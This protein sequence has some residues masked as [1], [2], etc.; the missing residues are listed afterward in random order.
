MT[1]Q[2]K[3]KTLDLPLKII[4]TEEGINFFIKNQKK[5]QKFRM[6]DN[7]EAYGF[8]LSQ[9]SPQTVQQMMNI[10]YVSKIE[11]SR[12]EFLSKRQE[13]VDISKLIIFEIL[14]ERFD[15]DIFHVLMRSDMIISWNRSN[16]GHIIDQRTKINDS[17]LQDVLTNKKEQIN[18]IRMEILEPLFKQ[19]D[20]NEKLL[21]EEKNIQL[22]LSEKYL[23]RLQPLIWFILTRNQGSADYLIML[24]DMRGHLRKYLDKSK[25]AE[26]TSLMVLELLSQAE[27]T[28][29]L[30]YAGK[31]YKRQINSESLLF[32]QT[33]R[34]KMLRELERN[35]EKL[36]LS[37]RITSRA[38]GQQQLEITIFNKESEYNAMREKINSR[39]TLEIKEK[40]LQEFY[41]DSSEVQ[42]NTDLGMY[43]LSYLSDAC[44]HENVKFESNVHQIISS[45]LTVINLKLIF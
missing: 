27:N 14:Y 5:L 40:S 15:Y 26:Y 34:E 21:P 38:D 12:T 44:R 36:Y 32:D 22:L 28:N 16:P 37:W 45:D 33:L 41:S 43:Y 6:A 25:I 10:H 29:L 31:I 11:I 8:G 23:V 3:K 1:E 35:N 17:Y 2:K 24:N 9:I 7:M 19:I 20:M 42:T 39:K 30:S 4:L 18:E 13:I